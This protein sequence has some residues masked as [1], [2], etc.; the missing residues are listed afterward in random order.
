MYLQRFDFSGVTDSQ[1]FEQAE[2]KVVDA[3]RNYAERSKN[4]QRLQRK[5]FSDDTE[6]G[7][8]FVDHCH[9]RYDVVLMNPP[10]CAAFSSPKRLRWIKIGPT[11]PACGTS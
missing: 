4:G 6:R 11:K 10:S 3:L 2:G 7:F 9:K 1:F 8:S 5:L